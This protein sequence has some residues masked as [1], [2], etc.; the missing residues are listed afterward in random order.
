MTIT[1]HPS[2][3]TLAAFAAG[4]LDEARAVVV[5]SHLSR[6]PHCRGAM[7]SFEAAGG[8]LLDRAEDTAMAPDALNRALARIDSEPAAKPMKRPQQTDGVPAPLSLYAPGKWRSIGSGVQLRSFA[9]PS[10]DNVKV[11]MLYAGP[12]TR[13]PHHK[14]TGTEWTCILEGAYRHDLGRYG[15][16]DFDEADE[17][18]EHK[19]VIET[20]GPCTCLVA[21]QGDILLQSWLGRLIQPFVR[22]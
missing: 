2:E 19:P 10:Q 13:L 20:G 8:A 21:L 1:H 3:E 14:H 15:A 11:F 22:F 17:R 5:A 6:C 12:G 16:G 18:V 7:R 4:H 9:V